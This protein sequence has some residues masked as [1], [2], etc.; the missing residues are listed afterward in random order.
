MLRDARA[1]LSL[2][3]PVVLAEMGWVVMGIVDTIAVGP[4]G[5]AAIGAVSTGSTLFFSFMV[6]GIGTFYALDTFI[7]QSY[8]AGRMD[9]CH[10][11]LFAGLQLAGAL[12]VVLIAVGWLLTGALAWVGIHQRRPCCF[13]PCCVA[14]CR[15]WGLSAH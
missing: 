15:P 5:P 2:A 8:G 9:E 12:S 7:S 1:T 10:R 14:T 3:W 4:L 13:L 6:F 11:W